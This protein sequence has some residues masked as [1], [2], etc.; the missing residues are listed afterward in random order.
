YSPK[1]SELRG[2]TKNSRQILA[3]M[4]K[5]EI[6]NTGISTLKIK[7]NKV[8]G[9]YIEVSKGQMCR[10]PENYERKQ[11]LVNAE[12]F[13]TDELKELENKIL[14]AED[15]LIKIEQEEY[16]KFIEEVSEYI[17]VIQDTAVYLSKIDLYSGFALL[18]KENNYSKPN[19]VSDKEEVEIVN[20]RH[21]VVSTRIGRDFI[22]N[23]Y[24][25]DSKS[26]IMIITGPNMSGKSTYIRQIA[27][28]QLLMQIGSF[29]PAEKANLSIAD[30]IFTRI[31]ANDDLSSGE[32]T[33]MVEM[34]E[35][36]NI[37]NSATESSLIILDEIGRGTSTYDGVAI[38][39]SIIEYL[40]EYIGAK[41]LFATHYHE[42]I[43]MEELYDNIKN[44]N[45]A[46]DESGKDVMFLYKI[47]KG[48]TDKSYGIHVAKMA[49]VPSEVTERA[50]EILLKLQTEGMFEVRKQTISKYTRR[51]VKANAKSQEKLF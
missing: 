4:Q 11:T 19:I 18:A 3:E 38:A 7:F 42:L 12:R 2:I 44:Y 16:T 49:G 35:A 37:L 5:R 33:F 10:V 13:I 36:A 39:W 6:E 14:T 21:P 29:V 8:F 32:S 31:G 24:H 48:G 23:N 40:H 1:I 43:K 47:E 26:K 9:Y 41:V 51:K 28:I 20:G 46:V 15:E 22:P 45:V 27:L 30:N 17:P 50:N 34:I 25:S